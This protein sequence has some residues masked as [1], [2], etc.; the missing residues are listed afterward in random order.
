MISGGTREQNSAES[1]LVGCEPAQQVG[2]IASRGANHTDM[3]SL[4]R[5]GDLL[6]VYFY[7]VVEYIQFV[8]DGGKM[9]EFG[10]F[11]T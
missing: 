11:R 10:F 5:E 4:G 3:F 6:L 1:F 8:R 7:R 9:Q 2:Y